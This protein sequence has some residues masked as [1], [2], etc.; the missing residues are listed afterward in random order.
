M[1][2]V[3]VAGLLSWSATA[4]AQGTSTYCRSG[5]DTA[6]R[7]LVD[8]RQLATST[9][10]TDAELRDSVGLTPVA[11]S[12]VVLVTDEAKCQQAVNA[13]NAA[14]ASQGGIGKWTR[15][16]LVRIGTRYAIYAGPSRTT[17]D[18]VYI[19]DNQYRIINVMAMP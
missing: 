4:R 7:I 8:M 16:Y 3:V 11:A 9:D 19:T 12:A 14:V 2:A 5:D 6:T 1:L 13:M 10:S 17:P 18:Y 15:L